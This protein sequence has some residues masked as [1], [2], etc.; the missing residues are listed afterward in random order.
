MA[1]KNAENLRKLRAEAVLRGDCYV[2]RAR[3]AKPGR[4]CCQDCIDRSVAARK[5]QYAN[6]PKRGLCTLCSRPAVDGIKTCQVHREDGSKRNVERYHS[7][8]ATGRCATCGKPDASELAHCRACLRRI[9]KAKAALDARRRAAGL[10]RCGARP[11][12]GYLTCSACAE[13]Q[14]V[15]SARYRAKAAA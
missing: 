13:A 11:R 4:R 10:C 5:Q 8:V 9:Y 2:C 7:K 14:A 12:S 1:S 15:Y 6:N 3:P